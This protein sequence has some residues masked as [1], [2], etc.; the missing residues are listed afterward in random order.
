MAARNHKRGRWEFHVWMRDEVSIQ[1]CL[2]VVH[3]DDW[4]PEGLP[5]SF[6][7]CHTDEQST[8]EAGAVCHTNRS[9]VLK[10]QVCIGQRLSNDRNEQLNMPS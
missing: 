2:D 1:M 6:S 9:D 4:N 3:R 8:E 10:R 5:E 7:G